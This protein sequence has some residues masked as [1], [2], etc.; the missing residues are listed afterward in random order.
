MEESK[1]DSPRNPPP[2]VILLKEPAQKQPLKIIDSPSKN[3]KMAHKRRL[4]EET[5]AE[6]SRGNSEAHCYRRMVDASGREIFVSKLPSGEYLVEQS[7]KNIKKPQQ[8]STTDAL[9]SLRLKIE[10]K[11]SAKRATQPE[12]VK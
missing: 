1:V 8:L 11:M 9:N 6:H 4:G 2:L 3:T 10:Q 12:K 7:P 5:S